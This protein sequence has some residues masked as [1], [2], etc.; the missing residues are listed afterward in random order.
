MR[1]EQS[2]NLAA[3][4]TAGCSRHCSLDKDWNLAELYTTHIQTTFHTAQQVLPNVIWEQQIATPHGRECIRLLHVLAVQCL[5]QTSPIT[6]PR[7]CYIHT[8]VPH[9]SY[10]LCLHM[11]SNPPQTKICPFPLG[12]PI[13]PLKKSSTSLPDPPPKRHNQHTHIELLRLFMYESTDW[14]ELVYSHLGPRTLQSLDTS[15]PNPNL[16]PKS[17]SNSILPY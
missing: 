13:T 5:L 6:Q 1:I 12:N 14:S 17:N 10:T 7:V 15:V 2:Q 8:T 16:Y 11:L 3:E 4:N 9:S